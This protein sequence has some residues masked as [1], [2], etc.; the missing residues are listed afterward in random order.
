MNGQRKIEQ[1]CV[2]ADAR[3]GHIQVKLTRQSALTAL[4][5]LWN[6]ATG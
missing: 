5:L 4:L 2:N 3:L 1:W 6:L